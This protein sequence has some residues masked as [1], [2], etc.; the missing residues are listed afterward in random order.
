MSLW[1]VLLMFSVAFISSVHNKG[2][3]LRQKKIAGN[4]MSNLIQSIQNTVEKPDEDEEDCD[5]TDNE[6][7][8]CDKEDSNNGEDCDED[9]KD[10]E[11]CDDGDD[12]E[13]LPEVDECDGDNTNKPPVVSDSPCDDEDDD[14]VTDND[15]DE[16]DDDKDDP[17]VTTTGDDCDDDEKDP[18][19]PD[20]KPEGPRP[21]DPHCI[22]FKLNGS[23]L[24]AECKNKDK[25]KWIIVQID[26][27]NCIGLKNGHLEWY[28]NN[29]F[30]FSRFCTLQKNLD[31]RCK[32]QHDDG[33]YLPASIDLRE[34]IHYANEK[35]TC[36]HKPSGSNPEPICLM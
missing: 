14:N 10:D 25:D 21:D 19:K 3:N 32:V 11:E 8:E 16:C 4:E 15:D 33:N 30:P 22:N 18:T 17:V 29:Y 28:L 9:K 27:N 36:P 24:S 2:N 23:I 26:L 6:D 13:V 31:M 35:L 5:E 20:P 12:D 7:E 1:F 34:N